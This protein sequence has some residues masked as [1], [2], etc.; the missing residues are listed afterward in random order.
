MRKPGRQEMKGREAEKQEKTRLQSAKQATREAR[1][2]NRL[3]EAPGY[4]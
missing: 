1:E 4:C 2:W 3:D